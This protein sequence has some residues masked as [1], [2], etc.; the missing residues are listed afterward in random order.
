MHSAILL[1]ISSLS[2]TFASVDLLNPSPHQQHCMHGALFTPENVGEVDPGFALQ[3]YLFGRDANREDSCSWRGVGC[4]D[5]IVNSLTMTSR[6]NCV[7]GIDMNWLPSTTQFVHLHLIALTKTLSIRALPRELRYLNLA[8]GYLLHSNPGGTLSLE[9]LPKHME[10]LFLQ[11]S[12]GLCG[13]LDVRSLPP[14]MKYCVLQSAHIALLR[15]D[16]VGLPDGLERLG[17]YSRE[18]KVKPFGKKKSIPACISHG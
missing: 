6:R 7:W 4:V 11:T 16:N 1:T 17:V 18:L 9:E 10:E 15:V 8:D 14:K 13:T 3:N 2:Q 5:G 12:E